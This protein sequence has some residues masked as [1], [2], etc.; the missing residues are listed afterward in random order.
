MKSHLVP[1]KGGRAKETNENT[2]AVKIEKRTK[3]LRGIIKNTD[4]PWLALPV[5]DHP[6][7]PNPWDLT[8]TKRQWEDAAMKYRHALISTR[9]RFYAE[10]EKQVKSPM[11]HHLM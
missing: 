7:A 1:R 8:M 5:C 2:D 3:A 9:T 4:F 10:L 6:I 11:E